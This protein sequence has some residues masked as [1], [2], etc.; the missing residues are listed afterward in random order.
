MRAKVIAP[1]VLAMA[2]AMSD[3]ALAR[4]LSADKRGGQSLRGAPS[5]KVPQT[6]AAPHTKVV[7]VYPG[8]TSSG[9]YR[10]I[11]GFEYNRELRERATSVPSYSIPV[12]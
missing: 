9:A 6:R 10:S 11:R 1:L 5:T 12:R 7:P 2:F 4:D 8:L 3:I